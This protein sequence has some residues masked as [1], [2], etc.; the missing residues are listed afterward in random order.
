LRR[1]EEEEEVGE[2]LMLMERGNVQSLKLKFSSP[3]RKPQQNK[4]VRINRDDGKLSHNR[5]FKSPYVF[6][7]NLEMPRDGLMQ[8][9]RGAGTDIFNREP[10]T[11]ATDTRRIETSI[12]LWIQNWNIAFT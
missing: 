4:K 10:S 3:R 9:S 7:I 1:I 2:V 11:P 5:L 12:A 8:G 6:G